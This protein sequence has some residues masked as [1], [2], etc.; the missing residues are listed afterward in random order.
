M[1][2]GGL[3]L[4][5]TVPLAC[6][7][8]PVALAHQGHPILRAE[9]TIKLEAD[10]DQGV[11]MVITVNLGAEEMLRVARR[12][13]ENGDGIVVADEVEDYM[14]EWADSLRRGLPVR[15]DGAFAR[16]AHLCVRASN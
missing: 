5:V 11:R 14:L 10:G 3:G 6:A 9:R 8:V 15:V 16:V 7:S 12:A 4:A 2:R 13:D 1:K